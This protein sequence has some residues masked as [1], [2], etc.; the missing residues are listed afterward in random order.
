MKTHMNALVVGI[1]PYSG[2]GYAEICIGINGHQDPQ[3]GWRDDAQSPTN[4]TNAM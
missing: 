1:H 3:N 2:F 4:A